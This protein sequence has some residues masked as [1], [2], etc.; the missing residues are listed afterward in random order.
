ELLIIRS[1]T[2]LSARLAYDPVPTE[3]FSRGRL[4]YCGET[5]PATQVATHLDRT[6]AACR[7]VVCTASPDV[8]AI[9]HPDVVNTTEVY[10]RLGGPHEA[11][12]LDFDACETIED[13]IRRLETIGVKFQAAQPEN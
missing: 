10:R 4:A 1:A 11:S 9:A 5:Q 13:W 8:L 6:E 7:N 3:A 12:D 2:G